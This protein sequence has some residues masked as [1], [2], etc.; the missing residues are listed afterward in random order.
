MVGASA[1]YYA[2][3]PVQHRRRPGRRAARPVRDRSATAGISHGA[4]TIC[5]A[6]VLANEALSEISRLYD[7]S[8]VI[9]PDRANPGHQD[10]LPESV[11]FNP[12]SR[13]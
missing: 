7:L 1:A 3:Q 4:R 9:Q 8:V 5:D 11:L 13:C 6:P 10:R 2:G 12:A